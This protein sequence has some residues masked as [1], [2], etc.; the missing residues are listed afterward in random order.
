MDFVT[1]YGFA[2]LAIL[3]AIITIL[4]AVSPLTKSDVDNKALNFLRKL[5]D[6][7]IR[8]IGPQPTA[9]AKV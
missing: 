5:Q 7:V 9:K 6:L 3:G 4:A 1:K 8:M 2:A